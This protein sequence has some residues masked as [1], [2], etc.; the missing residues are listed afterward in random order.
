MSIL[1][2][3]I[4]KGAVLTEA[5]AETGCAEGAPFTQ[6]LFTRLLEEEYAKLLKAGN[7]DV[8]DDSKGTTLPIAR[9]IV[10]TYV[11]SPLKAPWYVDLLNINL[12]LDDLHIAQTRI[13]AYLD[14]FK[15]DG[16]RLTE[17]QDF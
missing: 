1:W 9:A 14:A 12:G 4:H 2:E 6:A 16:T 3:W 10:E 17:N 5:D 15:K 8:H 13:A 11:Q 7:R